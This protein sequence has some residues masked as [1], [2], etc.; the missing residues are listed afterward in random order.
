MHKSFLKGNNFLLSPDYIKGYLLE[1]LEESLHRA[2]QM[3]V[4]LKLFIKEIIKPKEPYIAR[5]LY[6]S[7][8]SK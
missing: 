2:R 8:D 3:A 1:Q 4:V 6:S 7:H 5:I